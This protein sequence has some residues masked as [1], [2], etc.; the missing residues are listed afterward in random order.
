M[1]MAGVHM[2]VS[3]LSANPRNHSCHSHSTLFET[4]SQE[5]EPPANPARFK[6]LI[7]AV[8]EQSFRKAHAGGN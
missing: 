8:S 3:G 6:T 1:S 7:A 5:S 4:V 2:A